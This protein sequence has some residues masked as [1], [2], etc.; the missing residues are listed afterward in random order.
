[1]PR[2]H[3]DTVILVCPTLS[4]ISPV[5][6][7]LSEVEAGG[8]RD[9]EESDKDTSETKGEDDPESSTSVDVVVD[10]G[11]KE[12]TEFT[13]GSRETVGSSSDGDGE[14]LSRQQESRTIGTEL[15]EEG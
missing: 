10:N 7:L 15:L 2:V 3:S 9:E 5:S 1:M 4:D 6:I 8:V 14:D 11:G 13:G 12:G